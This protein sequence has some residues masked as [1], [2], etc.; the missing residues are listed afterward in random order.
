M[1]IPIIE[2][3]GTSL[4]DREY[5][6]RYDIASE[7][8]RDELKAHVSRM[9]VLAN[10]SPEMADIDAATV[11]RIETRLANASAP[12]HGYERPD[13]RD[14]SCPVNRLPEITDGFN[15]GCSSHFSESYRSSFH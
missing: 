7:R 13:R 10:D 14:F 9:F 4:P 2:Q 6:F 8:I 3:S 1:L 12:S 15:W 11:M 5:Y